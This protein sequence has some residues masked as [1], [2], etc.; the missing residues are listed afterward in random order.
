MCETIGNISGRSKLILYAGFWMHCK[1]RV[2]SMP[3]RE[4]RLRKGIESLKKQ[5]ILHEEKLKLAEK[6]GKVELAGYYE[7]EILAK[8]K[9]LEKKEKLL[10]RNLLFFL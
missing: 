5:L 4:N 6:E 8:K 3:N 2:I 10:K 7:K 1:R 9:D